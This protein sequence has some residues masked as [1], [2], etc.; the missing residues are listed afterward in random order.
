M[1]DTEWQAKQACLLLRV[2]DAATRHRDNARF[3]A[4][5]K[6]RPYC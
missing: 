5:L 2:R 4:D 3:T 1:R 6:A